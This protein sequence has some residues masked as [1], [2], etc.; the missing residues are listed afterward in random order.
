M[1]LLHA[2]IT[3]FEKELRT[4]WRTRELLNTTFVFVLLVVVLFSF[5]F[6]PTREESRQ[7]GP[8]LLWL[9]FLFAGSLMLQPAFLRELNNDTLSALRL[10]PVA[11]FAI[12]LGKAL[13]NFLYL[14][15]AEFL[16]LPIFA[17][18]YDVE[19]FTVLGPVAGVLTLG[20]V[21]LV[22]VGTAFSAI[23]SQARMR[24]LMLPLLM[25]PLLAPLL[26]ASVEA[27]TG[28][29]GAEPVV[30]WTAIKFLLGFDVVYLTAT[31][32]LCDYL[33]EE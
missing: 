8:G 12:F 10:A 2:T 27:T 16:L 20:T 24:E 1:S 15:L 11:P 18:L 3:I 29:L 30:N 28:L 5:T 23:T 4:E 19:I 17:A 31:Y 21:G 7:Y 9:S 6:D 13:A 14:L 22:T 33:L 26:I 32:L 25:L